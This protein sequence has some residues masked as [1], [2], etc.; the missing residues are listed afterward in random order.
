MTKKIWETLHQTIKV[1]Q[2]RV[3]I[4]GLIHF[5]GISL[6]MSRPEISSLKDSCVPFNSLL[7]ALIVDE[8][9]LVSMIASVLV[10]HTQLELLIY[11]LLI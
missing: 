10:L 3:L 1:V 4:G 2:I 6:R 11:A 5:F 7:H 9:T 8:R